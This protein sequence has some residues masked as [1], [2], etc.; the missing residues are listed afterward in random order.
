MLGDN[1]API[2]L[3]QGRS[4]TLDLDS[5]Y[6]KG[7]NDPESAKFYEADGLHLKMGKTDDGRRVPGKQGFDLLRGAGSTVAEKRKAIIPDERN[8][9]NLAVAQLH[10]AMIRFHNRVVD[11][12]DPSIPP[13][14]SLRPRTSEGGQALP[15]DAQDGLPAAHRCA[16]G[17]EQ[18][19]QPGPEGVRGER[20][21]DDV[22]TMP[23]EFSVA[24]FRLGHSMI[25]DAYNWNVA[26]DNGS[27][28]LDCLF[29]FTAKS[30]QPRRPSAPA[31]PTGPRTF[32][33]CST[34]ARVRP[35]AGARRARGEVQPRDAD[36]HEDRESRSPRFRASRS[37]DA[38]LALRNLKRAKMVRLATGQQMVSFLKNK[39]VNVTKLTNAADPRR[40]QRS[41]PERPDVGAAPVA[42][43]A[44]AALVLHPA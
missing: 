7:P 24:A 4:P 44:D 10:L 20:R 28:Y 31:R 8:D 17:R 33:G 16:G 36:R 11:T 25:R 9:E 34:S 37:V 35:R 42:A 21:A 2:D 32:A 15:V 23:I 30:G 26:F 5:M 27:G 1:V 29:E 43:P 40:Q 14:E 12:L 41:E 22:P 3:L 6:G 39:G 19:L 18:R 13:R 38:N